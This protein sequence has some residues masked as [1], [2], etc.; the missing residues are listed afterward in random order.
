M[1]AEGVAA[2]DRTAK[3]GELIIKLKVIPSKNDNTVVLKSE[4]KSK[5]PRDEIPDALFFCD[6]DGNLTQNDPEGGFK[7]EEGFDRLTGEFKD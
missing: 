2:A 1:L 4:V 5:V 7:F 6:E 3:P